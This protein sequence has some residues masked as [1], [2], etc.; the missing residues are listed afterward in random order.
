MGWGWN[1]QLAKYQSQYISHSF[2]PLEY[3]FAILAATA[4]R[5]WPSDSTLDVMLPL[6]TSLLWETTRLGDKT[7]RYHSARILLVVLGNI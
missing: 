2:F 4:H 5:T 6:G 1:R 7:K 3:W